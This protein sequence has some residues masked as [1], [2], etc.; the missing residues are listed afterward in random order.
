MTSART[1]K[2]GVAAGAVALVVLAV[3]NVPRAADVDKGKA[4]FEKCAACHALG[5]EAKS[6]GPSLKGLFG[7]KAAARDDF[8]YSAAMQRS[9]IVWTADTLDK[10]LA[11]PQAF[12][13]GNRMSF[14]GLPDKQERDDLIEYLEQA[15]K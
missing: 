6:D 3:A 9:D 5:D 1:V 11:D 4:A 7:R 12:V 2:P 10:F 8:R 13:K 15:T 14:A